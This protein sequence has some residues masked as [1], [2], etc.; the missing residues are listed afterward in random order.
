[1]PGSRVP[2][3]KQMEV[4]ELETS[5]AFGTQLTDFSQRK[6]CIQSHLDVI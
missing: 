1:M 3:G 4:G 2:Q 6:G 5:L